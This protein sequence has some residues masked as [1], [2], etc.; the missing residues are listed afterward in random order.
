[1]SNA[2]ATQGTVIKRGNGATP[3]VFSTI[4]EIK[5]FQGLRSGTRK[6]IDV[7]TLTST[8]KEFRLGLKDSGEVTF[9]LNYDPTDAQQEALEGDLD[10]ATTATNFRIVLSD[11]AGT[12]FDFAAFVKK[13]ELSGQPDDVIQ[14]SLVLR[15]SGD[16]VRS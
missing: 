5:G 10:E 11:G 3:E 12:Q 1:M 8:A 15:I 13:F 7:T 16:V 9:D 6:E 2:I 4:G 14:G